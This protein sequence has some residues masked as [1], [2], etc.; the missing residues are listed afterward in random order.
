MNLQKKKKKI[1]IRLQPIIK[2]VV[3]L[4]R[5][6]IPS[7]IAIA[8]R[9]QP[10]CGLVMANATQVHQI[11]MNLI[12]NAFHAVEATGGR[13]AIQLAEIAA[14]GQEGMCRSLEP[15]RYARLTVSDTGNGIDPAAK[16]KIFEPYFT[17]KEQGKGTGLGLSTVYG[18]VKQ[19][20]GEV[21]VYSE[22]GEGATFNVYLPLMTRA[23]VPRT[24]E[25]LEKIPSGSE[26]ILLVD[27]E[28]A[29]VWLERQML[30]RLG[31]RVT[32]RVSSLEALEAFKAASDA[33]DLVITDM[34]MPNMTGDSL[35]KAIKAIR[36]DI[37]VIICTG[38]SERIDPAAAADMGIRAFLMK[39][40]AKME[41]ARVVRSVLDGGRPAR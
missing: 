36:A 25:P 4:V 19:H 34:T 39:P 1:P 24:L 28:A 8:E 41:L 17:T 7:N 22:V 21:T 13:I 14:E 37:P 30:E 16:D 31:Y 32:S 10:D 26:R 20:K 18:I 12:T 38:F 40:V 2:E 15:G 29:I 33:Y 35:A 3:K 27:D 11:A 5:A 9:I 6:T 23:G